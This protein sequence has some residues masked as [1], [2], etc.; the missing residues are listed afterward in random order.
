MNSKKL[1]L[2]IFSFILFG[3]A[4]SI[5]IGLLIFGTDIFN[6]RSPFFQFITFGMIG[7]VSFA[8]FR[9]RRFRDSAYMN[10][11]LFFLFYLAW[12]RHH[13]LTLVFY[14]SAMIFSAYVYA[15][16]LYARVVFKLA[17]P[18]I[19]GVLLSSVFLVVTIILM[20]IYYSGR[21]P[22]FPFKNIPLGFLMGFGMAVGFE[23]AEWVNGKFFM[24]EPEESLRPTNE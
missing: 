24:E 13:V 17:R 5:L 9:F 3:T 2:S 1:F 14:F 7:S 20:L 10:L 11:L 21:I 18:F 16:W 8:L 22:F 6:V 19:L 4:C 12:G 15:I 23:I